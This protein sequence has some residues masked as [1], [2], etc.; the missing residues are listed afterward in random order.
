MLSGTVNNDYKYIKQYR[1]KHD[2]IIY[3]NR[4]VMLLVTIQAPQ[5]C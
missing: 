1:S 2:T 5:L 4:G 3:A